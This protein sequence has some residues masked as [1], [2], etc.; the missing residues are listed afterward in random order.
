MLKK[1]LLATLCWAW[2]LG[3]AGAAPKKGIYCRV[4]FSTDRAGQYIVTL[5]TPAGDARFIFDTGSPEVI[6]SR[7]L[8]QALEGISLP[9]TRDIYDYT[10]RRISAESAWLDS[11]RL[12]DILFPRIRANVLPDSLAWH[13]CQGYDGI[14]G[15]EMLRRWVVSIDPRDSCIVLTD[16]IRRLGKL[17]R[18]HSVRF[19]RAGGSGVV[20]RLKAAAGKRRSAHW[21]CIDTGSAKY[22]CRNDQF[23]ALQQDGVLRAVSSCTALEADYGLVEGDKTAKTYRRAVIPR[24]TLAGATAENVPVEASFGGISTLGRTILEQGRIVIDY[25]HRRF[26]FIPERQTTVFRPVFSNITWRYDNE[27]IVVAGIWDEDTQGGVA[28]GDHIVS[29]D[30]ADCRRTS[31]CDFFSLPPVREGTVLGIESPNGTSYTF[32]V[33]YS[34]P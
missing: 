34:E 26:F 8:A 22:A 13:R 11:L 30:G 6:V 23:S 2:V 19:V 29:I 12:G 21:A 32:T 10:N 3:A 7:S 27:R 28:P 5:S 1:V 33:H 17:P 20:I 25:P 24:L 18:K 31:L 14:L 15:G 16:D 4:P 9:D